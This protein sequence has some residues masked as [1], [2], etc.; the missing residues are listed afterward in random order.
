MISF[1]QSAFDAPS[2]VQSTVKRFLGKMEHFCQISYA[3]RNSEYG[4]YSILARISGLL[5][6]SSPSAIIFAVTIIVVNALNAFALGSY[7]HVFKKTLERMPSFANSNSP[8]AV[9]FVVRIRF[10]TA[11][12]QHMQPSCVSGGQ[13]TIRSMAV[14][15]HDVSPQTTARMDMTI[16]K[17]FIFNSSEVAA[18]A[19]NNGA[20]SSVLCRWGSLSEDNKSSKSFADNIYSSRHGVRAFTF[21]IVFNSGRPATTGARCAYS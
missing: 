6:P 21:D 4:N 8:P 11:S 13:F 12:V 1:C 2:K 9:I 17:Q 14:F 19:L 15:P 10:A 5:S 18:V 7:S 16:E 3:S 20:T